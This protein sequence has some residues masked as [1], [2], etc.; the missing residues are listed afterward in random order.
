MLPNIKNHRNL[1]GSFS[2]IIKYV[3]PATFAFTLDFT[4]AL[5]IMYLETS[6]GR[7]YEAAFLLLA[8]KTRMFHI[9][10]LI[11]MIE[12]NLNIVCLLVTICAFEPV[13]LLPMSIDMLSD[14]GVVGV[15]AASRPKS[16]ILNW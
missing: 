16:P 9:V 6:L 7:K 5:L 14:T 10:V 11:H 13:D 12:K 4:V 1:Q 3:C 2:F 8:F 15:E